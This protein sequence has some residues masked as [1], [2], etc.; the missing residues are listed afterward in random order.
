MSRPHLPGH[1]RKYRRSPVRDLKEGSGLSHCPSG[2]FSANGAW[3]VL[4]TVAHNLVRW[5]TKLGLGIDGPVVM[6]T[7]R[8]RYFAVPGRITRRARR[9]QLHLPTSWPWAEQWATCFERL[10]ALR[11]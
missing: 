10:C 1:S 7:V 11:T 4:A 9:R 3:A 8:R 5:V 2:D 6:K